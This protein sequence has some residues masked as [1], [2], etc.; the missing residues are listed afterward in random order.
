MLGVMK[1]IAE[2]FAF[3]AA[4]LKS[5]RKLSARQWAVTAGL[6]PS[7]VNHL[8]GGHT[9]TVLIPNAK[10]LAAVAGVSVAWLVD[11]VEPMMIQGKSIVG[12]TESDSMAAQDKARNHFSKAYKASFRS[13]QIQA[14]I[15]EVDTADFQGSEDHRESEE[16]WFGLYKN[17][18]L[19]PLR[20]AFI[21]S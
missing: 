17:A 4:R 20:V 15:A 6:S 8:I 9:G 11:G 1:T 2:R 10:K 7:V 13:A 12:P 16:F 18:L 5:E 3:V 21:A 14:A 19:E